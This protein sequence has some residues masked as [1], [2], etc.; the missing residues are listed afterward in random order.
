MVDYM[1]A[2]EPSILT[3]ADRENRNIIKVQHDDLK[4]A[5]INLKQ[6]LKKEMNYPIKVIYENTSK[7][8]VEINKTA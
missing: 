6:V 4:I 7:P 2:L 1:Y 5:I 8:W 3:T